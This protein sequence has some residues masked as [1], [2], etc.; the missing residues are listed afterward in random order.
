MSEGNPSKTETPARFPRREFDRRYL[1]LIAVPLGVY[2]LFYFII[3]NTR[4][5]GIVFD[6]IPAEQFGSV[7]AAEAK[8]R[9]F[10]I[11]AFLVFGA[12]ALAVVASCA[13][14]VHRAMPPHRRPL[15]ISLI[16]FFFVVIGIFETYPGRE[17][18]HWY[19]SMG[20]NLYWCTVGQ[21]EVTS[22]I[23]EAAAQPVAKIGDEAAAIP[24]RCV[25][26]DAR[27]RPALKRPALDMLNIG[28]DIVKVL[29]AAALIVIG[30]GSILTL[31]RISAESADTPTTVTE[32]ETKYLASNIALL[33]GYLYQSSA[34][35]AFAMIA[36]I[37]WM[38][39]P[40]PFVA[41]VEKY[42]ELIVGSALLQGVGYT[43]A[44]A[45]IYL[46][47]AVL[48]RH[49]VHRMAHREL[50]DDEAAGVDNWLRQKGL[51]FQPL[52]ELRQVAAM[53]L[54]VIISA[55]PALTSF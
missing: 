3:G 49:R 22:D 21:I 20:K 40:I 45:A 31:S 12:V 27:E 18:S 44:V 9:Y 30:M 7:A 33:K 32:R 26:A 52:D 4:N 1:L 39:W 13:M 53:L 28:I 50:V 23:N 34:V 48:L 25:V 8:Y 15:I 51:H 29:G 55:V 5:A 19:A 43:V 6:V 24:V 38:F 16:V 37:S 41:D 35:Y 42:R 17:A 11:S 46:P 2:L 36:M 47:P 54:P 10:W 14:S